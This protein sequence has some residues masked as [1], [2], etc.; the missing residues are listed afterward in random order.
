MTPIRN[1]FFFYQKADL[2][3]KTVLTTVI[4]FRY[5]TIDGSKFI[6]ALLHVKMSTVLKILLLISYSKMILSNQVPLGEFYLFISFFFE[7]LN[8]DGR[9]IRDQT[10]IFN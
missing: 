5:W 8:L 6:I 4:V 10:L 2:E 3:W 1:S 7:S 9:F